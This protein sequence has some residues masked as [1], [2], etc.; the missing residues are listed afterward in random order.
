MISQITKRAGVVSPDDSLQINRTTGGISISP[1]RT[2]TPPPATHLDWSVTESGG[3]YS[4]KGGII[5]VNALDPVTVPD[6][7]ISAQPGDF[8]CVLFVASLN[9]PSITPR[10]W[11]SM[12]D[13]TLSADPAPSL[14]AASRAIIQ[15]ARFWLPGTRTTGIIYIPIARITSAGAVE[16]IKNPN[17]ELV[18]YLRHQEF[19]IFD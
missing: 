8:I 6:A 3:F 7:F 11:E 13:Y 9:D 15:D 12:G 18:I 1:R 5:S 2:T 14:V 17:F 10:F 19:D 16:Q 4:C